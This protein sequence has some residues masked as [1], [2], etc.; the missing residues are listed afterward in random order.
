[1]KSNGRQWQ[2]KNIRIG[3]A[4]GKEIRTPETLAKAPLKHNQ[5]TQ[6]WP[7]LNSSERAFPTLYGASP[8]AHPQLPR[9]RLLCRGK[10]DV[11]HSASTSCN[12]GASPSL[13]TMDAR[14]FWSEYVLPIPNPG[15]PK[16]REGT[17]STFEGRLLQVLGADS[18]S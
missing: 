16:C 7:N 5:I 10:H 3:T 15:M 14:S 4:W 8:L 11:K 6:N 9:F 1:M 12:N 2:A 17:H 18:S 13:H